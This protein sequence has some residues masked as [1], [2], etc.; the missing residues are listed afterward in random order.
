MADEVTT[1]NNL[2]VNEIGS[3]IDFLGNLD[4]G[5]DQHEKCVKDISILYKV[6]NDENDLANKYEEI[7]NRKTADE[8]R[9]ATENDRLK[10]EKE[11]LE[12][13]KEKL[14]FEKEEAA[15]NEKKDKKVFIA[16][17]VKFG[18][19]TL[20]KVVIF[21]ITVWVNLSMFHTGIKF[22]ETGS[23]TSKMFGNFLNK[24]RP[25]MVD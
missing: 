12:F 18:V 1:L 15:K 19:E 8:A 6:Y 2:L 21:G 22:E 4:P 24:K 13:E 7:N 25:T 11:K 3:Q 9:T 14:E 10:F 20:V 16:D 23:I 17:T 5:T